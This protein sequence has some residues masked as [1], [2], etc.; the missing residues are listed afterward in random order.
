[1]KIHN[2]TDFKGAATT[3]KTPGAM[4]TYYRCKDC[5][6]VTDVKHDGECNGFM[7]FK[8][9]TD[10]ELRAITYPPELLSNPTGDEAEV[11]ADGEVVFR[12]GVPFQ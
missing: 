3:K 2:W 4:W 5:G 11:I 6:A 1:M 9:L 7:R 8:P 12:T 10:G